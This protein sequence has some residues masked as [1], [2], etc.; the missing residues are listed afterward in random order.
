MYLAAI[1]VAIVSCLS[2]TVKTPTGFI[3]ENIVEI[4][5]NKTP[6][7]LVIDSKLVPS[8]THNNFV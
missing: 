4:S 2:A 3:F 8:T 1:A 7:V 6:T 5:I